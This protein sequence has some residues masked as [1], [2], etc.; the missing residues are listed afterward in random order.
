[1]KDPSPQNP[2]SR[3]GYSSFTNDLFI[4]Q[5]I[6]V[7]FSHQ[8]R[9]R[10]TNKVLNIAK[11]QII[12]E[13]NTR[14]WVV[15]DIPE[16][17]EVDL[18]KATDN[19]NLK[20]IPQYRGFGID[21]SGFPDFQSFLSHHWSQ[22]GV[23]NLKSKLRKLESSKASTY[24]F[25]FGAIDERT[26]KELFSFLYEML[27]KRFS[28][29]RMYNRNLIHWPYFYK[30]TLQKI[31]E[32][33]AFLF[34]IRSEGKPIFISLDYVIE[35]IVFGFIQSFDSSYPQYNLGDISMTKKIEWCILNKI[36]FFDLSKGESFFKEKWSNH[37]YVLD[38]YLFYRKKDLKAWIWM[39]ITALKLQ[40]SQ[41]L[42]DCGIIGKWF[43]YDKFFFKKQTKKLENFDWKKDAGL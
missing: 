37:P 15:G 25:Y 1:M 17:L 12:P 9:I 19:W 13:E 24:D 38:Y 11:T 35:N 10:P 14:F 3:L 36:S 21:L 28:E 8:L 30:T 22:K 42:R 33:K 7:L 41:Y 4:D 32:K 26:Y 2:F 34:V 5:C 6:P 16:Y 43:Q 39:N 20:C 40:A 23:R 27:K 18:S 29:I 31:N